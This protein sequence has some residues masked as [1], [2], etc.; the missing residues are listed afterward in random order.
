[1]YKNFK[2]IHEKLTPEEFK[3]QNNLLYPSLTSSAKEFIKFLD[4]N[5]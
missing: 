5:E 3:L 4:K 2:N 1:M